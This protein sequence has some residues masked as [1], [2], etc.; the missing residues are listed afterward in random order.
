MYRLIPTRVLRRTI[1]TNI[2]KTLSYDVS[3]I[4]T[5]INDL[6]QKNNEYLLSDNVDTLEMFNNQYYLDYKEFKQKAAT[7]RFLR[8]N[9]FVEKN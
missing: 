2:D 3:K 6:N 4:N 1:A 7:E 5:N 8:G 9:D